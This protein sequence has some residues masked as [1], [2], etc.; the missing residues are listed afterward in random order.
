MQQRMNLRMPATSCR[1]MLQ[2]ALCS[3]SRRFWRLIRRIDRDLYEF[4]AVV[5]VV[6]VVVG[7][8]PWPPLHQRWR[9][10]RGAG[11]W[12]LGRLAAR[13][14]A[15]VAH[16]LR[17]FLGFSLSLPADARDGVQRCANC[18]IYAHFSSLLALHVVVPRALERECSLASL[19][20]FF[21]WLLYLIMQS[22]FFMRISSH[23]PRADTSAVIRIH[24]SRE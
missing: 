2:N 20:V 8:T 17:I 22:T 10:G 11:A 6:A 14:G 4:V 13:Y 5:A 12:L 15:T 7:L 23:P 9:G 1:K 19:H 18:A 16:L 21:F 3:G 24:L